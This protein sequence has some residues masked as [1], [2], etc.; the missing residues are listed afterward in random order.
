MLA[1]EGVNPAERRQGE[2][3]YC[4]DITGF[5]KIAAGPQTPFLV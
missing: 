4:I 5:D 1:D 3:T 2:A